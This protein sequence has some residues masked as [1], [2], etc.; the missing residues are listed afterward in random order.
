MRGG[1]GLKS[2]NPNTEGGEIANV[3][4]L[5]DVRTYVRTLFYIKRCC[6]T[7]SVGVYA[8]VLWR[9]CGG[10]CGGSAEVQR[11]RF[12]RWNFAWNSVMCPGLAEV[13]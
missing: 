3:V 9:F 6:Q 4:S 1:T 5:T 10:F 12:Y 7:V 11:G 8:K 2:N 13:L